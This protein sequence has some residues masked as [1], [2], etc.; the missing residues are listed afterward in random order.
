MV[1][2]VWFFS[3]DTGYCVCE[4]EDGVGEY[5]EDSGQVGGVGCGEEDGW[6]GSNDSAG[7]GE[8]QEL[9]G[10]GMRNYAKEKHAARSFV[11]GVFVWGIGLMAVAGFIQKYL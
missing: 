11:W 2:E 7:L 6:G 10:V 3:D 4:G 8:L 5:E 9:E 1:E